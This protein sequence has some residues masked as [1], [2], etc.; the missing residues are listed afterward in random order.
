MS[1]DQ[2]KLIIKLLESFKADNKGEHRQIIKRL[3]LTN[4]NVKENTKFRLKTLGGWTVIKLLLTT[5]VA[6]NII[7]LYKLFS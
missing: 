7:V 5:S 2:A 1:E 6:S 3:D 4:G